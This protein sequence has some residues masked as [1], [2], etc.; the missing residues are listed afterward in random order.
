MASVQRQ[1]QLV[2][3]ALKYACRPSMYAVHITV[4]LVYSVMIIQETLKND[5]KTNSKFRL[6]SVKFKVYD[7]Y[8]IYHVYHIYHFST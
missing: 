2:K 4:F 1:S 6:Y 3:A 5:V 7:I 8:N